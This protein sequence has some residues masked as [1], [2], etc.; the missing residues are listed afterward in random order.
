MTI[1][2]VLRFIFYAIAG[3]GIY[4]L[5]NCLKS[6]QA[7]TQRRRKPSETESV[8]RLE[9]PRTHHQGPYADYRR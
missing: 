5:L 4:F 7:M 8:I 3:I 6:L 1:E 2:L 9:V